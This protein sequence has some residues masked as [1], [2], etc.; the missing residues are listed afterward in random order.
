MTPRT[1]QPDP[2]EQAAK[3]QDQR[4]QQAKDH[5]PGEFRVYRSFDAAA[6]GGGADRDQLIL[7][8]GADPDTGN[9]FGK[10]LG[11]ADEGAQFDPGQLREVGTDPD[12]GGG[13]GSDGGG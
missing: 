12:D 1:T 13:G 9:V 11:W 6:P 4:K 10:P 7:V 3:E 2:A 5:K 8:T